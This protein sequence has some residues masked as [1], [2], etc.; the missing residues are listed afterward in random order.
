MEAG[1]TRTILMIDDDVA[2]MNDLQSLIK[3]QYQLEKATTGRS[4]LEALRSKDISAVLLDLGLP[5]I[6]GME[7]LKRIREEIDPHIPVIIVTT[8]H[9]I[10]E[11]V[12]AMRNGASDFVT[13]DVDIDALAERIRKALEHRELELNAELMRSGYIKP[14]TEFVFASNEM[15]KVNLEIEK[16]ANNDLD[17]LLIGETGVGKDVVAEEIHRRSKRRRGLFVEFSIASVPES[18]L[19]SELFG[20][21]K[22]A[23]SGAERKRA[24]VLEGAEGG[25]VYL[26]EITAL[27]KQTQIKLLGF[28][29]KKR[30]TPVGYNYKGREFGRQVDVRLI[31]ATNDS[32][33]RLEKLVESGE[34][35]ND[36]YQRIKVIRI[37]IPPLRERLDDIETLTRH[38]LKKYSYQFSNRKFQVTDEV[39]DEFKNYNW[40]GN[41]RELE[42]VLKNAMAHADNDLLTLEDFPDI[43]KKRS[44]R[45][46]VS[47][48]SHIGEF[49]TYREAD[50]HFRSE[51]FSKLLRAVNGN[52]AEAAKKAGLTQAG[53]RKVMHQLGLRREGGKP[54]RK[55]S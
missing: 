50:F 25:T 39:I 13:K 2:L 6:P 33:E 45:S 41:V 29:E 40:P 42:N 20:Y 5:D 47:G 14:A 11:A 22:G 8:H 26:P 30:I 54:S 12:Q 18:L 49:P 44:I 3:S 19:E 16:V 43:H 38:F 53:L 35:R 28:L 23:F 10:D 32:L 36:F 51:Y 52:I 9:N 17:V 1:G 24:G 37:I 7:V 4:G 34:L 15:K 55:S 46:G 27:P 31:M 48:A 21:E